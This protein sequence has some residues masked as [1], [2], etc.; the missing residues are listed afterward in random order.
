MTPRPKILCLS[1]SELISDA[2]VLRQ[3]SIISEFG[4]VT[5]V[6][7][8]PATRYSNEH[9]EI[10]KQ[11][12]SLPETIPGVLKLALR[13]HDSVDMGAPATQETLRLLD[14]KKFDCAV[15]NEIRA[16]PAGLTI[17]NGCPLWI[18]LHE[19]APEENSQL[20]VWRMLV[21]P[22]FDHLCKKLLP[23]ADIATT[24]GQEIANLYEDNYGV[25]PR[26][27]RNSAPFV[28]IEPSPMLPSAP[29][30]LVHSG[31]AVAARGLDK[32][33]EAVKQL[34][35]F[36]LDL[37][38]VPAGDGG[39]FLSSLKASAS[40]C[41]RISFHDPVKPSEIPVTLNSY[42]VGVYWIPPYSTNARLALPNKFFDFV[43]ARLA[44]AI[45]PSVEMA[46]LVK[47]HKLG[48]V[49]EG[50]EV[51]DIIRSLKTLTK[52]NVWEAKVAAHRAAKELSFDNEAETARQIMREL[53]A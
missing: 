10:P 43:Q 22:W 1:F 39:K 13:M 42:D 52:E 41:R 46:N 47:K 40:D 53:L 3:L 7:Y 26:L 45:G 32:M 28:D 50:F 19:W 9:Y 21:G 29:I 27:M 23:D 2:R 4:D 51:S 8:G 14:G 15:I 33:V 18:D 12:K 5:T 17:A 11:A 25:R 31:M 30:R 24:V 37:Y 20:F 35:Q 36:S 48:A 16:L 44:L 6:G 38:L 49:S 34:D